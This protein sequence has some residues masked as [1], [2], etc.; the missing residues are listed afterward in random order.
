MKFKY[1]ERLYPIQFY[2]HEKIATKYTNYLTYLAIFATKST[3]AFTRES[4]LFIN[5][6][7][8][9]HTRLRRTLITI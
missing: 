3:S 2:P 9:T 7:A 1:N 5:A 6:K 4:V 8:T